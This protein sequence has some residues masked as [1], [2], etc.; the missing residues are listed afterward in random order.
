MIR[1][2]IVTHAHSD[3]LYPEDIVMRIEGY[4]VVKG[5]KSFTFYSR[6]ATCGSIE[7]LLAAEG[8]PSGKKVSAMRLEL[9]QDYQV[10]AYTVTPLTANHSQQMD[11]AIYCIRSGEKAMLYAHDT[12]WFPD[13]TWTWLETACPRLDWVSLDCT[14]IVQPSDRSSSHMN[15]DQCAE[16]KQRMLSIGVADE[17]TVFCLN[18]FSH[19]GGLTYDELRPLAAEHGFEIS[20]DGMT[21][22]I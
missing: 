4:A 2:C 15:L 9:F 1:S 13:E 16:V 21:V 22:E 7:R 10:E 17:K 14:S 8:D 11:P 20:Y 3:H 19:N 12:G 6:E 5:D 18:H